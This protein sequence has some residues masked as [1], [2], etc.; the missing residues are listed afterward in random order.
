M[1]LGDYR[2]FIPFSLIII[3]KRTF[4]FLA[5]YTLQRNLFANICV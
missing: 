4:H 2:K 1:D 3:G 5:E